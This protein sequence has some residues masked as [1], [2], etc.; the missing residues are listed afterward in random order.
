MAYSP[1]DETKPDSSAAGGMPTYSQSIRDNLQAMRDAVIMGE[2]VGWA[3]TPSGGTAEQPAVITYSKG[4]ERIKAALTW[5]SSGGANGNV[6]QAVYSYSSDG[7]SN[8]DAI[9]TLTVSYDVSS[10]C[11]GTAW[12]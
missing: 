6:E 4:T 5:G 10:N 11:T 1:F 3:M 2:M 12:S 9:G 8:W 7:G